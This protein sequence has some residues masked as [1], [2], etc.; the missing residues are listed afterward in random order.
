M[1][2]ILGRQIIQIQLQNT[3]KPRFT[4]HPDIP[5]TLSSPIFTLVCLNTVFGGGGNP[6]IMY[7]SR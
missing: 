6:E 3:A 7:G 4:V 5:A 1:L 2:L